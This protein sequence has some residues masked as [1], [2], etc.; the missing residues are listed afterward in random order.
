M[1]LMQISKHHPVKLLLVSPT[2]ACLS[3]IKDLR[4]PRD[5]IVLISGP[6]LPEHELKSLNDL[7]SECKGKIKE[8]E[9]PLRKFKEGEAQTKL[10]FL[11]FSSG[12]TGLPKAV[13]IP[14]ISVIANILQVSDIRKLD[15]RLTDEDKAL[16]VLPFYHI[17]GLVSIFRHEE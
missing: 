15:H 6:S 4:F 11:S 1:A 2:A 9:I 3:V 14:H 13:S 7:V 5:R 12:T 17:Y 8:T 10:A 16:A